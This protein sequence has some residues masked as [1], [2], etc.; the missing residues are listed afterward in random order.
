MHPLVHTSLSVRVAAGSP[1][2]PVLCQVLSPPPLP[3]QGWLVDRQHC[4]VVGHVAVAVD[5]PIVVAVLLAQQRSLW[6]MFIASVRWWRSTPNIISYSPWL[7]GV[8][9]RLRVFIATSW[10][11]NLNPMVDVV[12][13][14]NVLEVCTVLFSSLAE[15]D[16][17]V[18][19]S[20]RRVA[21]ASSTNQ[22]ST[23]RFPLYV[24]PA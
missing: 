5:V 15:V 20:Y 23:S 13:D 14:P 10:P 16:V 17:Q 7:G 9:R 11:K 19:Q 4:V 18:V 3:L 21:P 22:G 24:Q 8:R 12:G 1:A 2:S 6:Q